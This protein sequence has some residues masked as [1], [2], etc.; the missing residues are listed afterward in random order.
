MVAHFPLCFNTLY[1]HFRATATPQILAVEEDDENVTSGGSSQQLN[2]SK[3]NNLLWATFT[4]PI[5]L[6]KHINGKS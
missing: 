4:T 6:C 1:S 3:L 2:K 5:Q